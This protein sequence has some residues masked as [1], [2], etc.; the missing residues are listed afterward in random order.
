MNLYVPAARYVEP[1]AT[2]LP[3]TGER[4]VLRSPMRYSFG[5]FLSY[6]TTSVFVFVLT[7]NVY[8]PPVATSVALLLNFLLNVRPFVASVNALP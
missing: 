7:W 2:V 1:T 3:F 8:V 5:R 4:I 6:L